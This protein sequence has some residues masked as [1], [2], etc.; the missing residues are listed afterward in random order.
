MTTKER[1]VEEALNL[2]SRKGYKGTSVRDIADAVGIRDSSLYKHFENKQEILD[3]IV[4]TMKRRI[5]DMSDNLGLPPDGKL[6]EA[7]EVYAAYDEDA[8]VEF[9]R[10]IF[11]FYAKDPFVSRFWRMG[12]MEQFRNPEVYA[13]FHKFFLVDG[14]TYQTALF[15]AMSKKGIFIDEDP[16][17]IA[18]SFYA[19]IFFL[20]SK[21][22]NDTEYEAS[23]LK[24]LDKQ[25]R[26]LYRIYR[27][28]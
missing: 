16:E 20:L 6:Q 19:P 14:L 5:S 21:Y 4:E 28:K 9:C 22:A 18:M 2:F 11:L 15:A 10:K 26:A 23:A 12:N 7:A 24:L 8:M 25:I 13:V 1:I 3:T 17:V 27:R